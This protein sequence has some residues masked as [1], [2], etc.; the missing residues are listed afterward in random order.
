MYGGSPLLKSGLRND[1]LRAP[2]FIGTLVENWKAMDKIQRRQA[3][4]EVRERLALEGIRE[5]ML[6]D[7]NKALQVHYL[8]NKN[9]Y[10]GWK[11]SRG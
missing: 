6:F 4:E 9:K 7:H 3:A 2:L 8:R 5:V 1:S 11:D 10:P